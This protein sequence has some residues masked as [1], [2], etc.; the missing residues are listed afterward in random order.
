MVCR[1]NLADLYLLKVEALYSF[2]QPMQEIEKILPDMIDC[3]AK[4]RS[5]YGAHDKLL[6]MISIPLMLGG[7]KEDIRKLKIH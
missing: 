6:S 7:S 4:S 2:S 5:E 1:G 3:Y